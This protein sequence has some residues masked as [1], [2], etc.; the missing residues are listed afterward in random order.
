MED[1]DVQAE[2]GGKMHYKEAFQARLMKHGLGGALE[3]LAAIAKKATYKVQKMKRT[4]GEA[5]QVMR[6]E[7][8]LRRD[9]LA[10]DFRLRL[11]MKSSRL[12]HWPP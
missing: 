8:R 11:A 4:K 7:A 1:E 6:R 2:A 12:T 9:K 3:M 5:Q 10:A